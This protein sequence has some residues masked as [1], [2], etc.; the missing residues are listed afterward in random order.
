MPFEGVFTEV[1]LDSTENPVV[2]DFKTTNAV[3]ADAVKGEE[4]FCELYEVSPSNSVIDL[5]YHVSS[6]RRIRKWQPT[7]IVREHDRRFS[8]TLLVCPP[9][10][11]VE[12][13]HKKQYQKATLLLEKLS[14]ASMDRGWTMID[15][16]LMKIYAECLRLT[17][18]LKGHIHIL[19]KMLQHRSEISVAEGQKYIDELENDLSQYRGGYIPLFTY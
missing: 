6:A 11:L 9:K 4:K 12:P 13:S 3:L 10:D 15:C 7:W 16:A 19:L 17:G 1:S 18:N 2:D 14:A 5:E 8:L